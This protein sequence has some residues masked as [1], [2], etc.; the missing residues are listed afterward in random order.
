[1]P[2]LILAILWLTAPSTTTVVPVV[3]SGEAHTLDATGNGNTDSSNEPDG[4]I[5]I[6][7]IGCF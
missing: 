1:M 5:C 4:P 3:S 7:F 6:P 2:T